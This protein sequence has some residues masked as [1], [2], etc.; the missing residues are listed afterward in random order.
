MLNIFLTSYTK[1]LISEFLTLMRRIF[2]YFVLSFILAMVFCLYGYV[3]TTAGMI[4][5]YATIYA[6]ME[7]KNPKGY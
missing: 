6:M 7:E 2:D 1:K 4:C 3:F 5:L